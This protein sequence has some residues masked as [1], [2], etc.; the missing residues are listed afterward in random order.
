MHV[1]KDLDNKACLGGGEC[2]EVTL[3]LQHMLGLERLSRQG[4]RKVPHRFRINDSLHK[5]LHSSE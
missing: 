5:K 4:G 1:D 3:L 2:E